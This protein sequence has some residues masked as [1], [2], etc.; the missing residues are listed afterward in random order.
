MNYEFKA[1]PGPWNI[2]TNPLE[3]GNFKA[4]IW[5]AD[6]INGEIAS[7][8]IADVEKVE[9][10][11]LIAAAPDLLA[12]VIRYVEMC[13]RDNDDTYKYTAIYKMFKSTLEKAIGDGKT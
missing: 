9:D 5:R 7:T 11:Q 4:S 8:F 2:T 10:A 13:E 12:C 1:T 6:R 3:I